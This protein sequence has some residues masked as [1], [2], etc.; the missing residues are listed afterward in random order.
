MSVYFIANIQI[1]DELEYQKY[2][3]SSEEVFKKFKGEYLAVDERPIILEGTWKYSRLVLISFPTQR[4]FEQWY[5]SKE[6]Q[7]IL[8]HRLKG[9]A[10]DTILVQAM[11]K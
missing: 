7:L 11:N 5:L 2:L 9:A 8:Q 3:E 1:E 10:C 4:E 6:Y